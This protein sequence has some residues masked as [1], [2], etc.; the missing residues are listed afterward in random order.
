MLIALTNNLVS[1]TYMLG[2]LNLARAIGE[3]ER[4]A[5]TMLE[6]F[7][8]A[9]APFSSAVH[10]AVNPLKGDEVLH[11]IRGMSEAFKSKWVLSDPSKRPVRRNVLGE[12]ILRDKG[13]GGDPWS[14]LRYV[15]VKDDPVAE[16]LVRVG[17]GFQP[18]RET[19]NGVDWTTYRN[20]QNQTAYD[21]WMELHGQVQIGGK[22]MRDSLA[23]TIQSRGYQRLPLTGVDDLDSPRVAALRRVVSRYREVARRQA[24]IEFPDL[25]SDARKLVVAARMMRAGQQVETTGVQ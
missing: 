3:P 7:A 17:A 21:R 8:G 9:A 2:A 24:M 22:T 25:S 13:V 23:A 18:P 5:P 15:E 1:K 16:E 4:F 12:P 10:Q 20:E 19:S 11:E 6:G 14:P